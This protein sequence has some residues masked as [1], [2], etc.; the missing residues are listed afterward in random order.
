M[1]SMYM[2]QGKTHTVFENNPEDL[3]KIRASNP[4]LFKHC[5]IKSILLY[6]YP[7]QVM[8]SVA[9]KNGYRDL[10]DAP[11]FQIIY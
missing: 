7:D 2:M 10:R 4:G 5:R 3:Q 8:Y 6:A 9:Y 11:H 1:K